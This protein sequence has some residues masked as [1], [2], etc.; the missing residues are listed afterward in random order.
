M[1]LRN[2]ASEVKSLANQTAKATE[3]TASQIASI[4][5]ATDQSVSAIAN[6]GRKITEMDEI[7]TDIALAVEEQGA[8]TGEINSNS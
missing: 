8:S 2:A 4:Q 3:Q 6:I 5:N 7:S 1:G